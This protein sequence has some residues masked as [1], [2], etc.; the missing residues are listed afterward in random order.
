M[1][2]YS[3]IVQ[4]NVYNRGDIKNLDANSN[5]ALDYYEQEAVDSFHSIYMHSKEF[6]SFYNKNK[7][8][9]G[10]EGNV[11]T[12]HLIWDMDSDRLQDSLEDTIELVSRLSNFE[13]NNIRVY[14]SGNKGFHVIYYCLSELETLYSMGDHTYKDLPNIIKMACTEMADGL[15]TFD[16]RIYNRTR[17]IRTPNSIHSKSGLYKVEIPLFQLSTITISQI[18]E[19]ASKQSDGNTPFSP[20][21]SDLRLEELLLKYENAVESNM[22][23]GLKA[24]ELLSGIV[25]GFNEGN[26]N[27]GLAS[28]AGVLHSRCIDNRFINAILSCINNSSNE[29]LSEK[30]IET[31][32]SSIGKYPVSETH[33]EAASSDIVGISEAKEQWMYIQ[34]TY[35]ECGF[36]ERFEHLTK[37]MSTCI[38]GD[39]IGIV[40]DSGVGKAQPLWSD[41][42]TPSGFKRMK[43][44]EKGDY[45]TGAN[46]KP[47]KVLNTYYHH[48][49]DYYRFIFNDGTSAECDKDHLW[50]VRRYKNNNVYI[51]E[52]VNTASDLLNDFNNGYKIHIPYCRPIDYRKSDC[53]VS[54]FAVHPYL[55][56]VLLGDGGLSGNSIVITNSEKDIIEKVR[57]LLPDDSKLHNKSEYDY[58]VIKKSHSPINNLNGNNRSILFNEL[59]NMEMIGKKSFEKTIPEKYRYADIKDRIELLR[60]LL[61]TDGYVVRNSTI[62]YST[63]SSLLAAQVIDLVRGLGG[64][65]TFRMRMGKYKKNGVSIETRTNYRVYISMPGTIIPVSSI[66]HLSKYVNK[67]Q[68]N[69]KKLIDIQY[70]GKTDTKCIYID[71]P[72]HLYITDGYNVTHNTT[73]GMDLGNNEA[74]DNGMYSL[75]ISLEMSNA[76][77]FFRAATIEYA[78]GENVVPP[79][80]VKEKLL[81]DEGFASF[82]ENEW[83]HLLIVEKGSVKIEDIPTYYHLAQETT[84]NKISN[85]IIDYAQNIEGAEDYFKA[86]KI[87]RQMKPMAKALNTKLIV[88]IQTNKS[89]ES[90][91]V[92]IENHNIEGVGAWRHACDY[93]LCFW[94]DQFEEDRLHGKFLKER[95]NSGKYYFDL[96]REGLKYHTEDAKG[97]F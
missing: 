91:F 29:P 49:R 15:K 23:G 11:Y 4:K 87:A 20:S 26:R 2:N 89:I 43:E 10:Y 39:V 81:K 27:D 1:F 53:H 14:F 88:L 41:V 6:V 25:N 73:I 3:E 79:E 47:S 83:K 33:K 22:N 19:L 75:M 94:K 93:M 67:R 37:R 17:I 66:K 68:R 13:P 80:K 92:E 44:I 69:Y 82:V 16:S 71:S 35:G 97:A 76:G 51:G 32:V 65:A 21:V 64:R 8:V 38:P 46:G 12:D 78:S 56:G 50:K 45:V 42:L 5:L 18:K 72:D 57:M 48:N 95:W 70:M 77:L 24:D 54:Q 62:E 30:E 58:T 36:G 61:D 34:N 55:M 84:G 74:R 60:G 90:S 7:S 31:I 52:S 85:V 40:S 28:V 96:V 59:L 86:M 9:M 63:T